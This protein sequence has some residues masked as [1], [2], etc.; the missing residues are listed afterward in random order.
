MSDLAL[1]LLSR[2]V[3]SVK[4]GE[5]EATVLE[6]CGLHWVLDANESRVGFFSSEEDAVQYPGESG[7]PRKF[8]EMTQQPNNDGRGRLVITG[9]FNGLLERLA[10]VD[11][12]DVWLSERA[13]LKKAKKER[14][15]PTVKMSEAIKLTGLNSDDILLFVSLKLVEYQEEGKDPL[16]SA[17]CFFG[18]IRAFELSSR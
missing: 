3:S 17:N 6:Y 7:Y 10:Q 8:C 4:L 18:L 5:N 11:H 12:F 16:L 9:S 2:P 1:L 13:I 15:I 14:V